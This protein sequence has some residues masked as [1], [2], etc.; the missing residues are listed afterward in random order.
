MEQL[1][2]II[3]AQEEHCTDPNEWGACRSCKQR[4]ADLRRLFGQVPE[5][6]EEWR[7]LVAR[8]R[9]PVLGMRPILSG[10]EGPLVRALE[11]AVKNF[12][13]RH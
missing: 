10:W 12:D 13:D 6:M 8:V 4:S 2:Q 7:E 5:Q 11:E 9:K 3:R 1:E